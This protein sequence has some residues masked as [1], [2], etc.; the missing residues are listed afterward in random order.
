MSSPG[1]NSV[2]ADPALPPPP[3]L[4][5][6]HAGFVSRLLAI[7][8]DVLLV[9]LVQLTSNLLW[10]SLIGAPPV[11]WFG[12]MVFSLL[13]DLQPWVI[14]IGLST[15]FVIALSIIC[16]YFLFF[17]TITGQTIGKRVIG[18]KVVSADGGRISFRQAVLRLV[19]YVLSIIPLYFGFLSMLLDERRRTWHDRIAGTEVIYA[20]DAR[21]DERF[22]RKLL[23]R[24]R[25]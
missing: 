25:R 16:L 19:G 2:A 10:T 3:R 9:L 1:R 20:W 17:F 23:V 21:P 7:L 4:G 12:D 18:L 11:Q 15:P 8:I 24:Q 14:A 5:G 22:L 6:A 13:P